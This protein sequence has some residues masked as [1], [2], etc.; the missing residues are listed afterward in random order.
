MK[1]EKTEGLL[2][3]SQL[4]MWGSYVV[5][6]I[7]TL[8]VFTKL[9]LWKIKAKIILLAT[10]SPCIIFAIFYLVLRLLREDFSEKIGLNS[11]IS[12]GMFL[13]IAEIISVCCETEFV[14]SYKLI[15]AIVFL[16]AI[17]LG[18]WYAKYKSDTKST[19]EQLSSELNAAIKSQQSTEPWAVRYMTSPCPYCGHYKVRCA[20]WEDKRNSVAFWGIHSSKIGTNY[21]CERCGRMWE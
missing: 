5:Y 14:Y 10:W 21:K 16:I 6:W 13:H 12:I 11:A 17:A 18:L 9:D 20:K 15:Q 1:K 8:F 7:V 3:L 2:W 4:L 19:P